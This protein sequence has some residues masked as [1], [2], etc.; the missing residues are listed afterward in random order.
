MPTGEIKLEESYSKL[1]VR[2]V[3]FILIGVGGLVVLA[4]LASTLGTYNLGVKEVAHSVAHRVFPF[5]GFQSTEVIDTVMWKLRLPRI[6]LAVLSGAGLALAGAVMQGAMRNPLVSPFT[7][8]VS[9]GAAFGASIAIVL[10]VKFIGA[11]GTGIIIVN[12]FVFGLLTVLVVASLSS[13]KGMKPESVILAGI[14]TNYFFSAATS[15]LQYIATDEQLS[16]VVHWTFG[17]LGKAT[18]ENITIV[19]II[20]LLSIVPLMKYSWD[21]NT[22]AQGDEVATSLGANVGRV[23]GICLTLSSLIAAVII[24]F[25]GIIGFVG[26][27]APHITRMLV[28]TDHRFLLPA[29]CL[30]GAILLLAADTIGRTIVSPIIIP[31]GIIVSFVGVP[32]F[33][34][35]L[36]MQRRGYWS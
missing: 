5:A 1:I 9:A 20:L 11:T 13:R 21:L 33:I 25:T 24:A 10:G 29:S 2:K 34:Y 12:A 22:M 31:V 36:L 27:V 23:R 16:E 17:S 30:T 35:L 14:A 8:G 19:T 3:A 7:V 18:W 28:G 4:L 32:L 6:I 15:A 26:L